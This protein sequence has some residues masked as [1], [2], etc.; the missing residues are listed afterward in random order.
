MALK[1]RNVLKPTRLR[2]S[3]SPGTVRGFAEL[4]FAL[5]TMTQTLGG[6]LRK[7]PGGRYDSLLSIHT[8][9]L[10]VMPVC[11]EYFLH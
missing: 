9:S 2:S 11:R 8:D 10:G 4:G 3:I 5:G 6:R 7:Q 1:R